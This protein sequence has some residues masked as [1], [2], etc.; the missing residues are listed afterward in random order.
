M[1]RP[2]SD[3]EVPLDQ[4][5]MLSVPEAAALLGVGEQTMRNWLAEGRLAAVQ[6]GTVR[7]KPLREDHP[8][9]A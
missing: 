7:G 5:L 3:T 6:V 9:R 8:P 1:T 4:R 2:K